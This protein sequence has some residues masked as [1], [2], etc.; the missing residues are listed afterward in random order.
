M[1]TPFLTCKLSQ[2]YFTG[3][4]Y[5]LK[6]FAT[7]LFRFLFTFSGSLPEP[8]VLLAAPRQTCFLVP[9]SYRSTLSVPILIVL[10]VVVVVD[11]PPQPPQPPQPHISP[12]VL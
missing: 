3:G 10:L 12:P 4:G 5:F 8:S 11:M 9:V 7:A 2:D 1:S 6:S